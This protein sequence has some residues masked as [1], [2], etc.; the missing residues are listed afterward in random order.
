MDESHP[1]AR[2]TRA[3]VA[4]MGPRVVLAALLA[5]AGGAV[6]QTAPFTA[7]KT[8]APA[9]ILS[10][11]PTALTIRLR[12]TDKT[13]V[14]S[15]ISFSDTFP[16][17]MV[18][19]PGANPTV[20][21]GGSLVLSAGGFTF[22][23]GTV[24]VA[25]FCD[26]KVTVTVNSRVDVNRTNT[27]SP[28][29]YSYIDVQQDIPGPSG[30][31]AVAGLPPLT[32]VT[33]P[34][35]LAPPVAVSSAIDF[36]LQAVGGVP[37]YRWSLAGGVLP[38]GVTLGADGRLS[39]TPGAPG[40]YTFDA[41]VVDARGATAVRTY[42]LAVVK[43][44]GA[45][46]VTV[47]PS[48]ATSGQTVTI[49]ATVSGGGPAPT[50]AVEAWV[51]GTGARCP[52]PFEFG[53]P[54]NPV[55][56]VRAAILDATGR[57]QFAIAN[58]K[59]D[60][61]GVCVRY[62][63]DA[64]FSEAFAGPV[65]AFVIKGALIAPP[66]IALSVPH[67]VGSRAAIPI[68]VSVTP[69]DTPLVPGGNVRILA[70]GQPVASAVLADGIARVVLTAPASPATMELSA[71]YAGDGT[72]P[73]ASSAPALVRILAADSLSIPSLSDATLALLALILA[74]FAARRLRRHPRA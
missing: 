46:K 33:P 59:I 11:D 69:V 48:P 34:A 66:T 43:I 70:G 55:A 4:R 51:A 56:P 36:T 12:N 67:Q 18:L 42:T 30:A 50:G 10:G 13:L 74:G 21:C 49:T 1:Q 58:L 64:N 8:F 72:F 25:S 57:A 73:P 44:T 6:G 52:P 7:T 22:A 60:D 65:D 26:V 39:G 61:Y 41:R 53:D 71:E 17:G 19:A 5:V 28:I 9:T 63:G 40:T 38:P 45:F 62:G 3:R 54:A 37:P 47:N 23:D 32:I 2:T 16:A 24:P 20:Q 31:L 15:A 68:R 27:T 14:A 29:A 35:A